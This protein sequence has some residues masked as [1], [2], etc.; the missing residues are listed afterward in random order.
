MSARQRAIFAAIAAVIAVVAIVVFAIGG[1]S[2]DSSSAAEVTA[3]PTPQ[4]QV[5]GT[6]TA[7]PTATGQARAEPQPV[8]IVVQGGEPKGGVKKLEL[9]QG[10][11][12]VFTV[13]SDVADEI[14][15]HGYDFKK[16]V[17]KG[18]S[19][20]FDFPAKITGVFEVELENAGVQI[21]SLTVNP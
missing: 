15:V 7:S 10:D 11:Q 2:D 18:G 16:D 13:Q 1:S 6:A 12:A 14:H 21:A 3:T 17:P 5:Q 19:V 20:G 4:Q 8:K 9:S